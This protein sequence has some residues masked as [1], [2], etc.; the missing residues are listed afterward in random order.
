[1]NKV[2]PP[3][4]LRP[5]LIVHTEILDPWEAC[6]IKVISF[7]KILFGSIPYH[8]IKPLIPA[9]YLVESCSSADNILSFPS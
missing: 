5:Y 9:S 4:P 8:K 6:F 2:T 1:M 3:P 7:D